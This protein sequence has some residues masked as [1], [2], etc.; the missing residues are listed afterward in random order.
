MLRRW[1]LWLFLLSIC[2]LWTLWAAIIWLKP[3]A[4]F[5]PDI[6]GGKFSSSG[7]F[8]DSFGFVS[9]L[10]AAIAAIGVFSSYSSQKSDFELQYFERNFF[11]LLAN[12]RQIVAETDVTL[13]KARKDTSSSIELN[14]AR[15]EILSEQHG[16]DAYRLILILIRE[17]LRTSDYNN[18]K[19]VGASYSMVYNKF[20]DDLGHY[21]RCLYHIYKLIDEKC[22]LNKDDYARIIRAHL[23]NSELCL[24]AYNC[25]VGEGCYEFSKYVDKYSILH[26]LHRTTLPEKQQAEL[27][28]FLRKL[29]VNSFRFQPNVP[30]TY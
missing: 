14:L 15:G 6:N 1:R 28:F 27:E 21:F 30:L 18:I 3:E 19:L 2:L 12:F 5:D 16:R 7:A 23:S 8:G 25:I 9:S 13:R 4:L 17:R 11:T 10:M 26:N 29:P 24:I 22:P 20:I